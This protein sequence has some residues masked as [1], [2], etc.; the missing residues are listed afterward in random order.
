MNAYLPDRKHYT[1]ILCVFS[2]AVVMFCL[3]FQRLP[4]NCL[5]LWLSR[6]VFFYL[7]IAC[8]G[9]SLNNPTDRKRWIDD[10]TL[11]SEWV[12]ARVRDMLCMTHAETDKI[13]NTTA[14]CT[15]HS[16]CKS[17]WRSK[18]FINKF[19]KSIKKLKYTLT[20]TRRLIYFIH[21]VRSFVALRFCYCSRGFFSLFISFH[22]LLYSYKLI[23]HWNS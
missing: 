23:Y 18:L 5:S 15:H 10:L 12:C 21:F 1:L 16:N 14:K 6:A 22:L 19:F 11:G 2:I 8:F 20:H 9:V 3:L 17:Q 13:T 4:E 7:D